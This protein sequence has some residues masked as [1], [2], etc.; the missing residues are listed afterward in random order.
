MNKHGFLFTITTL[1][2]AIIFLIFL[3]LIVFISSKPIYFGEDKTLSQRNNSLFIQ[4]DAS[5]SQTTDYY[6]CSY[7]VGAYDANL[8]LRNQT[9]I[10]FKKYCEGYNGKRIV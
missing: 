6:W 8:D 10:D 5:V 2:Y 7:H 4:G 9:P 3:S 1:Y